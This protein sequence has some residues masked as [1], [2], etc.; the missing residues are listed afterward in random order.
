MSKHEETK[1]EPQYITNNNTFIE[2]EEE[3]RRGFFRKFFGF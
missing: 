3:E 1:I 2:E